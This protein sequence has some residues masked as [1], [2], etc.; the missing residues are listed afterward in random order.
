MSSPKLIFNLVGKPT[1]VNKAATDIY[2]LLSKK[3]QPLKV[4]K[5]AKPWKEQLQQE[6]TDNTPFIINKCGLLSCKELT[7]IN[8]FIR[9]NTGTHPYAFFVLPIFSR[10]IIY[11]ERYGENLYNCPQINQI[12]ALLAEESDK[13]NDLDLYVK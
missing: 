2:R 5:L 13:Q 1:L 7:D 12:W 6:T 9:H 3:K 11:L 10:R 8:R 4:I